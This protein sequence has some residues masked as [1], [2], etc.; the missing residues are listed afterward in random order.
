MRE[1]SEGEKLRIGDIVIESTPSGQDEHSVVYRVSVFSA[2]TLNLNGKR[3]IYPVTY[4]KPYRNKY[5][6]R[7]YFARVFRYDK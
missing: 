1:I 5:A 3:R 7:N 6:K 4:A 2:I